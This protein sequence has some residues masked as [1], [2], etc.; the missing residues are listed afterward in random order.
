MGLLVTAA[1][2]LGFILFHGAPEVLDGAL[3]SRKDRSGALGPTPY[4]AAIYAFVKLSGV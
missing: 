3:V 2:V 1:L 4:F